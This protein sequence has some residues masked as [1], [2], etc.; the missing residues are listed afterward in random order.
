[1]ERGNVDLF[2]QPAQ[3]QT[4][5]KL[6]PNGKKVLT[7][8]Q[9][10]F[11][12]LVKDV[13]TVRK[14][15]TETDEILSKHLIYYGGEL[16]PLEMLFIEKKKMQVAIIVN[17]VDKIKGLTKKE[18]GSLREYAAE[19]L[20]EILGLLDGEPDEELKAMFLKLNGITFEEAS[21][22]EFDWMKGDLEHMFDEMGVDIDLEGLH[23]DM[24]QEEIEAKMREVQ[25][26]LENKGEEME[27]KQAAKKK[28]KKQLERELRE[29]AM[30]QV[31]KKSLSS[32]YK[33]LA[34]I[35]HPDL[36]SDPILK[37][38]KEEVMKQLTTAYNNNDLHTL[39]K[40]EIEWMEKQEHNIGQLTDEKLA[41]YNNVLRKQIAEM[42]M[43][44]EILCESP[45]YMPLFRFC[46]IDE[47]TQ[48]KTLEFKK[49]EIIN[50][51]NNITD[52]LNT[53]LKIPNP[54][55]YLKDLANYQKTQTQF[56][57]VS[58]EDLVRLMKIRL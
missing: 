39:L 31:K 20:N 41:I 50:L 7:K 46:D 24:S 34:K 44:L 11:N 4:N 38:Q 23:K 27:K 8:Q 32:I 13:E 35:L 3:T 53:E 54:I 56:N 48:N 36:E 49:A 10:A 18:R 30:E 52:I 42:K 47:L 58:L 15:L 19:Q 29:Q 12:R 45:R 26:E 43:E 16:R 25:Q 33:Q 14:E 28:T 2:G 37:L 40:L 1:M 55:N 57:D 51:I 17:H 9:K 6:V 22:K 21:E 5:I